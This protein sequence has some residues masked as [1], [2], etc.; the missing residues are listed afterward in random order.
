MDRI[1]YNSI[2]F[3]MISDFVHAGW[4]SAGRQDV[5]E[6]IILIVPKQI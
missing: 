3:E 4:M 1:G 2:V 6:K 5:C